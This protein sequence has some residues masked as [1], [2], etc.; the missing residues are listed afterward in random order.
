MAIYK[1][2]T[3]EHF[4]IIAVINPFGGYSLGQFDKPNLHYTGIIKIIPVVI[5]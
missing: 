3:V 1:L 2:L 4:A 5:D